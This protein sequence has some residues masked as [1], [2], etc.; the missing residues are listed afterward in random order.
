MPNFKWTGKTAKGEP[1][2]GEMS[3]ASKDEVIAAL[4]R[5]GILPSVVTETG[6]KKVK[7]QKVT[8]KDVVVFTRQFATMFIAG[9]PIVQGLDIMSKQSENKTLG[10]I[11]AQIKADVETGT[12]LADAMK[13]HPRVFDDLFVNLVAAGEA[14]GVLDGVL[15]RLANYMEKSMKLK[16]KVKGA[17]I[18][19]SI[20]V[21]VA[22][23]VIAIIMIFVI[24]IFAKIFGEMGSQLPAPTRSVIWLSDFLS[25]IGGLM[26]LGGIVGSIFGIKQ[27]RRTEIGRKKTDAILLKMPII[28]DLVRKVA[29]ARFTRTLGTLLNSGVPILDALDI[30]ARSSGNKVVEEVVFEVRKEVSAGKTVAEPMSKTDVFPPMVTQ[31]INVGESTGALDQMLVKIADF[32]DD[33][34]D[35]SVGNL[36]TMLE[37]MLM[38]FLGTAVGYIVIALYL[39]IFK[40]G[41]AV[42]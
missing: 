35:D 17:M 9:I 5:Q 8:D 34:V 22:V 27:Y 23:L 24:P 4:R 2:S 32:Y 3:A 28:G 16:K 14:G 39:P 13:K 19:P 25:G 11:I 1:K 21:T 31:M 36:T 42:K 40:M 6:A 30:C 29:V 7:K 33:E 41:E 26:I 15:L 20:V 37:P 10:S 18:Y 12:T 38:V